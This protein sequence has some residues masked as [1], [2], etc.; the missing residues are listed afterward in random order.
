[1][2]ECYW[3]GR[4]VRLRAMEPGD[5]EAYHAWN[6]D[7]EQARL[8]YHV[9]FPQSAEAVR[10]FAEET[11]RQKPEGDDFRFVITNLAGA[12]VGDLTTH[13]CEPRHGSFGYGIAIRREERRK[14]YASEAILIVL[15]YYFEELRY[16]KASTGIY[17]F[18]Q[19]SL[20]LH[21]KLG[22]QEEGRLRAMIYTNGRY[23]DQVLVGM[24]AEEFAAR[25]GHAGV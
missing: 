15:R 3:Q 9:P 16:H 2:S 24:T 8:L 12:V 19:P 1:M 21:R 13:H 22:F 11:A 18:N 4:L 25:H 14:G 10:R 6:E 23:H 7:D 5:W 17:A 20:A